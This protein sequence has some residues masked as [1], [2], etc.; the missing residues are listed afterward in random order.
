MKII[1]PFIKQLEDHNFKLELL[2]NIEILVK[3][4]DKVKMGDD[5]YKRDYKRILESYSIQKELGVTPNK[6]REYLVRLNGEYVIKGEVLAERLA[7]GGL[8]LKKI[9]ATVDGLLSFERLDEGFIDIL[10]EFESEVIKSHI[11]GII[12][13]FDHSKQM[14]I[15]SKALGIE[16]KNKWSRGEV[17]GE[18]DIV[19]KGDSVYSEKDLNENYRDKVVFAGRFAYP[20]LITQILKRGAKAVVVWSM[21]YSDYVQFQDYVIILGGFGQIPFDYSFIHTI[22]SMNGSYSMITDGV[23]VFA[24]KGQLNFTPKN[25]LISPELKVND[26]VRVIESDNYTLVGKVVDTT[27]GNGYYTIATTNGDRMLISG[28]LLEPIH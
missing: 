19:S 23:I 13:D 3:R 28:N 24:D 14:I 9:Y 2:G 1:K 11:S 7:N 22:S 4:G 17:S 8:V 6:V 25:T 15:K 26:L 12:T 18:F 10:S 27:N 16:I 21:N 20:E 5:L